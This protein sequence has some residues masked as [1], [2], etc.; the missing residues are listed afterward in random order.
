M[1]SETSV[2]NYKNNSDGDS[3]D[4]NDFNNSD[5]AT[6][7]K[8]MDLRY[9]V[10]EPF[11]MLTK[12]ARLKEKCLENGNPEAHYIEGVLRYFV[13]KDKHKGLRHLR[14]SSMVNNTNG[15]YL[16]GLLM[17]ALGHYHKGKKYLDKLEWKESLSTSDACLE[18]L[19][20]LRSTIS[21]PNQ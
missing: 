12:H 14:E 2:K 8:N 1:G 18:R 5:P 9:F 4:S 20:K 16:Y 19:C 6:Y 21:L 15:T 7:F 13:H 3:S 10:A 11:E 17:L